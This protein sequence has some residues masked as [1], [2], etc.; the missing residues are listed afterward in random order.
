VHIA[1]YEDIVRGAAPDERF[2]IKKL[3]LRELI[4][5]VLE[6]TEIPRIRFVFR[7]RRADAGDF[8]TL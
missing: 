8:G 5:A 3:W 4:V 7:T 1:D 2:V 6:Q